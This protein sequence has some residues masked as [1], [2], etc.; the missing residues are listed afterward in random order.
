M[1]E[2]ICLDDPHDPRAKTFVVV[3]FSEKAA[4]EY[5]A[6]MKTWAQDEWEQAGLTKAEWEAA[7][8]VGPEYAYYRQNLDCEQAGCSSQEDELRIRSKIEARGGGWERLNR[9]IAE[10]RSP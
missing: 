9:R 5:H 1:M 4:N 7:L 8:A 2:R 10:F 6:S 3:E